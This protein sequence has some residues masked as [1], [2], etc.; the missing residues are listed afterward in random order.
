MLEVHLL[1]ERVYP[2]AYRT[3]T[4]PPPRS[5]EV[6]T[7]DVVYCFRWIGLA[8]LLACWVCHSGWAYLD[9]IRSEL[10]PWLLRLHSFSIAPAEK[11]MFADRLSMM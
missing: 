3:I 7:N 6:G 4:A 8:L 1:I 11:R 10:F 5:D 9:T 2:I